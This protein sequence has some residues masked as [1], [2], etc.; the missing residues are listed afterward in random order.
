MTAR[1]EQET[2]ITWLADDATVSVYTSNTVHLRRLR[3]L[4]S[5][6]SYVRLVRERGDGAEFV[7]DAPFFHLFS[8]IRGK[9]AMSEKA[10]AASAARLAASRDLRRPSSVD[11][12][13][14]DREGGV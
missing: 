5:T 1:E 4:D 2:S 10:K 9:R 3:K 7:I 13:F 6:V 11:E 12:A 14:R 8:A